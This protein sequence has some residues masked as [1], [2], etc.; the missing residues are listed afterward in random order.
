MVAL[1]TLPGALGSFNSSPLFLQYSVRYLVTG[2]AAGHVQRFAVTERAHVRT[3]VSYTQT[4]PVGGNHAPIWQNCAFYNTPVASEH[5]VHSLEHRAVWITY[6]P[7]L[8]NEQIEALRRLA[9]QEKYVLVSPFPDLPAPV[10]ALA[11]GR[12]LHLESV[13][14]FGVLQFVRALRLGRQAPEAGGPCTG[15]VGEPE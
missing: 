7:D 14:D 13:N 10:V 15:G 2:T 3:P 4:P 6:R 8:P 5:A 11:W 12:Q 9:H 1:Q